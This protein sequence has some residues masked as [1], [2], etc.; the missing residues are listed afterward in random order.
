MPTD[1]INE[2]LQKAPWV[3]TSCINDGLQEA[4][5]VPTDCINGG[6][7]GRHW[8]RPGVWLCE[9]CPPAVRAVRMHTCFTTSARS[10]YEVPPHFVR[11][12]L[13]CLSAQLR[14]LPGV[15]LSEDCPPAV[16]AVRLRT[17]EMK[18]MMYKVP[19]RNVKDKQV[20]GKQWQ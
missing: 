8:S 20:E 10:A 17:L 18:T 3:P 2:G 15:W 16:R 4:P 19:S 9:D 11:Q 5:W 1:C 14:L 7:R 12:R 6:L 13:V